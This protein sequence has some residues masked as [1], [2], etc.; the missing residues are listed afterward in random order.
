MRNYTAADFEGKPR[1]VRCDR[2]FG[3]GMCVRTYRWKCEGCASTGWGFTPAH[4]WAR[5]KRNYNRRLE[6][7]VTRHAD[8]PRLLRIVGR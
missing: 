1:I 2:D 4:A 8:T 7:Y 5:W 3:Q 6:Y